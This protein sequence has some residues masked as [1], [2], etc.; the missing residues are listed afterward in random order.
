MLIK[1]AVIV[2]TQ[3]DAVSDRFA[4]PHVVIKV[5][6]T[7]G[8]GTGKT[9]VGCSQCRAKKGRTVAVASVVVESPITEMTAKKD[10]KDRLRILSR[11]AIKIACP[12]KIS[13]RVC[14]QSGHSI[15]VARSTT[16]GPEVFICRQRGNP[17]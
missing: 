1:G 12:D 3:S 4:Q 8:P 2:L 10:G 14:A 5:V 17:G 11:H 13:G 9:I 15:P 6:R 16:V 7:P